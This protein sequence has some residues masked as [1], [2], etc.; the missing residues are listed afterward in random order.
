MRPV[1]KSLLRSVMR[2]CDRYGHDFD[3]VLKEVRADNEADAPYSRAGRQ[4]QH[5]K[6]KERK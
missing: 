1:L 3:G 2:A 5:R 4:N 6:A